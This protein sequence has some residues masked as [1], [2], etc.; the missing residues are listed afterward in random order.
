MWN[1]INPVLPQKKKDKIR[2]RP[3]SLVSWATVCET[4]LGNVTWSM[5]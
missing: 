5:W 4:E 3:S 2:H 1:K